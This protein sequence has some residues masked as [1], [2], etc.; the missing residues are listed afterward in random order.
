MYIKD[1]DK[2]TK[3]ED[4]TKLSRAI[5]AIT[6]KSIGTLLGWKGENPDYKNGDSE[7]SSRCIVIQ[8]Q[9]MAGD[10]RDVYYPKVIRAVAKEV[11]VDKINY[12]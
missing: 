1:D 9:S 5:Q 12:I 2:W 10:N 3:E 11:M 4:H 8:Q 7:F 6:R